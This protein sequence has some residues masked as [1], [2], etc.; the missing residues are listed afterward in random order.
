MDEQEKPTTDSIVQDL[1]LC[2]R[3][4]LSGELSVPHGGRLLYQLAQELDLDKQNHFDYLW[5]LNDETYGCAIEESDKFGRSEHRL[6]QMDEHF[7]NVEQW[8]GARLRATCQYI[9]SE[10]GSTVLDSI[11]ALGLEPECIR[12][13]NL[14]LELFG[15]R[16]KTIAWLNTPNRSINGDTP[17]HLLATKSGALLVEEILGRI[18]HGLPS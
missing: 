12:V 15:S 2:A 17:I 18:A 10:E 14:A 3:L 11:N 8:F 9:L 5:D 6:A 4:I 1:R 16:D 13:F 7:K